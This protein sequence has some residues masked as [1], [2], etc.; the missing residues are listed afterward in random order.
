MAETHG[1]MARRL[2]ASGYRCS[3][4]RHRIVS[5]IDREDW[6]EH[7][8]RKH[9]PWSFQEGIEWVEGLGDRAADHYRRVYSR[10]KIE[11][12]PEEA[13]NLVKQAGRGSGFG[14]LSIYL[15]LIP[16]DSGPAE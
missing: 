8:A 3:S 12:V 14:G 5:R 2:I 15:P 13:Y 16:A 4:N 11:D 1:Q 6:K 9:A 7:M 10:D